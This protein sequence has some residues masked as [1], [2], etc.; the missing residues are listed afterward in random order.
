MVKKFEHA[1]IIGDRHWGGWVEEDEAKAGPPASIDIVTDK[2]RFRYS[3]PQAVTDGD[4]EGAAEDP[5]D[6][7]S[8][9]GIA[10]EAVDHQPV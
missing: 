4:A 9:G 1:I 7:A 8:A 2:G 6:T 10:G 3:N 5:P